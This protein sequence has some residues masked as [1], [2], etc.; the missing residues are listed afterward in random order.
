MSSTVSGPKAPKDP[1]IKRPYFYIM[2]DKEIYA[3][4]LPDGRG[5]QFIYENDGRL[6]D[7]ARLVGNVTDEEILRLLPVTEGFKKLVH[8]VG[9]SVSV[10]EEENVTFCLQ[11]Y[12]ADPADPSTT[13]SRTFKANGEEQL[14]VLEDEEWE[15]ADSIVGQIRFEFDHP[16]VLATVDVRLYLNDGFTAPEQ[17][18]DSAVDFGSDAYRKV[19][20]RSLM[21]PGETSGISKLLAKAKAGQDITLGFI[22]GSITQGAGAIPIHEKSYARVFA[23]DFAAR[24]SSDE[25]VKLI[26][27]GVGGT[28]S[29]LGIVRFTRDLLRDGKEKPDLIVIEFAVNDEGDETKGDFFESL[30]RKALALPWHPAVILLFSVFSSDYNLQERLGPVGVHLNLPMVSLKDAVTPQFNLSP[31]DGR[32]ISKNQYFYDQYHPSNNGHIV[33]SDCIMNLIDTVAAQGID[34]KPEEY[35][36]KWAAESARVLALPA[37]K[38]GRFENTE[39]LD[40]KDDPLST[41]ISYE[42]GNFTSSDEDLQ[43]VEMDSEI[44][45]VPEFPN[46]WH[47]DGS[48]DAPKPFVLK[49]R[50]T[51]ILGVFKDSGLA[52]F[53][54]AV[55]YVDGTKVME[56]NPLD[57][58]W[59]HCN[60]VIIC[61]GDECMEHTVEINMAPGSEH[62]KFTI[63]GFGVVE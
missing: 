60:A 36:A 48:A 22:G 16:G 40:K 44:V 63:L 33:M 61:D 14:I 51:K 37:R 34:L 6:P 9:V 19:I 41:D 23:N 12:P 20:G 58:G 18:V 32:V 29:E 10:Q 38:S 24:Y 54:T 5:V 3:S 49:C 17:T 57:I 27:A 21:N 4:P 30:A 8:S 13:V 35:D 52:E 39:L 11:M 25:K 62:K 2:N 26:K 50:C 45:P 56:Y 31:A 15:A 7:S 53:G 46:N 42:N 43:R 47:Y 59:T 28:P 55:V 1:T